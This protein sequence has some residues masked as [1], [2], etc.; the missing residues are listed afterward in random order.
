MLCLFNLFGITLLD[1]KHQIERKASLAGS[2]Q[3]HRV[4]IFRRI[5]NRIVKYFKE[6]FNSR[7]DKTKDKNELKFN[8]KDAKTFTHGKKVF[9]DYKRQKK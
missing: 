2:Q 6:K 1:K 9:K 4:K 3:I 8:T 7:K 5:K